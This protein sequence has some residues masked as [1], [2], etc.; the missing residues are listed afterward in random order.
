MNIIPIEIFLGIAKIGGSITYLIGFF[1]K[2]HL[3]YIQAVVETV[4]MQQRIVTKQ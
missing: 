4:V 1:T 2:I 3:Q